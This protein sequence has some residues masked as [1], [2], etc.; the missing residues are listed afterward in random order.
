MK[1]LIV[2]VL[3]ALFL[4]SP[5]YALIGSANTGS[6]TTN[7]AATTVLATTGALVSGSPR[8]SG[9]YRVYIYLSSTAAATFDFQTLSGVGGSVVAHIY[10]M[11]PASSSVAFEPPISF[12]VPDGLVLQVVN[13]A[14]ITGTVQ[15]NIFWAVD[16][17]N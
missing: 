1:S 16:T 11:V 8:N 15:A 9:N 10:L 13:T 5:S 4:S 17:L 3:V 6:P 2:L 12:T 14:S 7:P